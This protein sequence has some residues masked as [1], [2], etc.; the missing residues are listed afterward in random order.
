M[1]DLLYRNSSNEIIWDGLV[2]WHDRDATTRAPTPV[3]TG[4]TV[5]AQI[6]ATKATTTPLGTTITL[7]QEADQPQNYYRG[8]SPKTVT[9]AGYDEVWIKY[10]ID[11]GSA[12]AYH[13]RWKAVKVIDE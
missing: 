11:G 12:D 3:T 8:I 1:I 2:D 4:V 13:E 10:I 5:T 7:T 9:L 6:Y